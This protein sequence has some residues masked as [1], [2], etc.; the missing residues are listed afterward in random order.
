MVKRTAVTRVISFLL[1]AAYAALCQSESPSAH[2]PQGLHF[3]GSNVPEA[4]RQELRTQRSLPDAPSVQFPTQAEKFHAFV[5]EARSPLTF[6]AVINAGVMRAG[7]QPTF[8][9]LYKAAV[10]Q[11]ESSVFFLANTCIRCC[12]NRTRA[13]T[14]RPTTAFWDGPAAQLRGF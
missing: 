5:E 6:G 13:I 4:Q 1:L 10:L 2:L 11:K 8:T 12:S 14:L 3:D 9:A 7:M